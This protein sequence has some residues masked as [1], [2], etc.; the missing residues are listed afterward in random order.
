MA[1]VKLTDTITGHD[2]SV[3]MAVLDWSAFTDTVS[4][5]ELDVVAPTV[6]DTHKKCYM[7]DIADITG[8]LRDVAEYGSEDNIICIG[9]EAKYNDNFIQIGTPTPPADFNNPWYWKQPV[10]NTDSLE[11]AG[12]FVPNRLYFKNEK[13][14]MCFRTSAG[15]TLGGCIGQYGQ[16]GRV[17]TIAAI[18]AQQ[19]GFVSGNYQQS[20]HDFTPKFEGSDI[21]DMTAHLRNY[22][23]LGIGF[24][25]CAYGEA[26]PTPKRI[27]VQPLYTEIDGYPY[28]GLAGILLDALGAPQY[29]STILLPAW[30]W[31]DFQTPEDPSTVPVFWGLDPEPNRESGTYTYTMSDIDL[32]TA[33]QPFSGISDTSHGL[34][35]YSISTSDYEEIQET[36]WGGGDLSKKIWSKWINY[37]FNPVAGIIGCHK[38]PSDFMPSFDPPLSYSQVRAAGCPLQLVSSAY[39]VNAKTT[40]DESVRSIS[41]PKILTSFLNFSPYTDVS[42]F[43]PFCGWLPIPADRVVGGS[44]TVQYRCD[45]ITGNVCAFVRCFNADGKNTASYQMTGNCAISFPVTGNDN[46]TGAVIGAITAGAGI[47]VGALT[48]TIGAAAMVG[49][50][51]A[52]GIGTQ[53][54]RNQMQTGSTYSGSVAALGCLTPYVVVTLPIEQI[55]KEFR[56]LHGIESAIG[57]KVEKLT[58]TG[59]TEFSQFHA[60][61]ACT[62]AEQQ[63]IESIMKTGVIL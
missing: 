42:L 59:Y 1:V 36:L 50:A 33:V 56:D 44:L 18:G 11:A 54:G 38:I 17:Y 16:S 48:G 29:V 21:V 30:F 19:T 37:K 7:L 2:K 8:C 15:G 53:V 49:G 26:V 32:P 34:H 43:L 4:V 40:V 5:S 22:A 61:I 55:S 10:Q 31:G 14:S 63:E 46:G 45:I 57:V 12:S 9:S 35:V 24:D 51:A 23:T 60:D 52:A 47:A 39:H 41:M 3:K 58:G 13:A 62:D 6:S 27:I 28:I 25:A 20:Y